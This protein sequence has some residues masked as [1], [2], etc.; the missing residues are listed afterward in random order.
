MKIATFA[1]AVITLMNAGFAGAD[2]LPVN[3]GLWEVTNA[4]N[5]PFTGQVESET[6]QECIL[7]DEFDPASSMG[8]Q[9]G[10][11]ITESNLDGDTLTFSMSCSMQG[12]AATMHGV[13][14]SDG[15]SG[16][17]TTN[18]EYS[19]GGKTMKSEGSWVARRLGDC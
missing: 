1:I 15:N 10:C 12:G 18:M 7:Q 14:Q 5:S 3:S 8:D 6:T 17:G 13:Y 16:K 9:E 4:R 19:F 11:E 2:A